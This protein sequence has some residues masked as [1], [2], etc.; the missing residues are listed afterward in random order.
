MRCPTVLAALVAI[1][2]TS[3]HAAAQEPSPRDLAAVLVKLDDTAKEI[4]AH[5]VSIDTDTITLLLKD[6]RITLPKDRVVRIRTRRDS[7]RNG[8][9]IGAL[10]GGVMCALNCGQGLDSAG[11]F[12]LAVM[13]ATGTWGAAGAGIDALKGSQRI[14]YERGSTR[15][16]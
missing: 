15:S 8:A 4:K 2:V 3:C 5:L 10:I 1:I 6:R 14:L 16:P 12:P 7:I 11:E 9:A 13:F